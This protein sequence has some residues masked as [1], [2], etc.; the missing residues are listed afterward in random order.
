[1]IPMAAAKE[2]LLLSGS[3]WRSVKAAVSMYYK[4]GTYPDIIPDFVLHTPAADWKRFAS[5]LDKLRE[6]H[7]DKYEAIR[8]RRRHEARKLY[9]REYMR[10]YM[11]ERRKNEREKAASM[12]P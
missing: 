9:K 1:M 11:R 8:E 4:Y 10:K 5:G 7:A 2:L 3:K 12:E 6:A